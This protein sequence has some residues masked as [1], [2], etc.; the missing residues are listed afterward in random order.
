MLFTSRF[1]LAPVFALVLVCT[2]ATAADSD[3]PALYSVVDLQNFFGFGRNQDRQ[4]RAVDLKITPEQQQALKATKDQRDKI[5][6]QFSDEAVKIQQ[7][8][9]S[10]VER[11][12]KLRALNERM[13]D[14]F[15]KVYADTLQPEQIKRMKQIILQSHGM[16]LFDLPEVRD[17]LKIGDKE[18]KQLRDAYDKLAKESLAQWQAD[19]KAKKITQKDAAGNAFL[20]SHSV[21]DKVRTLLSTNQQKVLDDLIGEKFTPT[22]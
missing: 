8:K 12:T 14:E 7:A 11:N 20:M 2:A 16:T 10:A 6:R 4:D 17:A 15:F 9:L 13:S 3:K 19:I 5:G 21:P 1:L 18:V 22:K